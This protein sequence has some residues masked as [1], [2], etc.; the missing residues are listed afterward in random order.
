MERI[1][2]SCPEWVKLIFPFLV[3][4]L[5]KNMLLNDNLRENKASHVSK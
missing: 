3:K 2:D 1:R 4:Q 5:V